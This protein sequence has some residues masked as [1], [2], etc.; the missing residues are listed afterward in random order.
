MND[1][2]DQHIDHKQ[3]CYSVWRNMGF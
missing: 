3:W 1:E 2:E